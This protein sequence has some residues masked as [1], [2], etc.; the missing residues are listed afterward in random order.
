M[1]ILALWA[2][3]KIPWFKSKTYMYAKNSAG[4]LAPSAKDLSGN[5]VED[6]ILCR[7]VSFWERIRQ[8]DHKPRSRVAVIYHQCDYGCCNICRLR[9]FRSP[10]RNADTAQVMRPDG[11]AKS[12]RS[13]MMDEEGRN[14]VTIESTGFVFSWDG[15]SHNGPNIANWRC[16]S[17]QVLQ[18]QSV[19][20]CQHCSVTHC[21][22]NVA[23]QTTW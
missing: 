13:V 20:S 16:R 8:S 14:S 10:S 17:L 22:Y 12:W 21:R 6:S 7:L 4:V 23:R 11:N 15:L 19:N 5:E 18:C 9:L 3:V 1:V 2:L